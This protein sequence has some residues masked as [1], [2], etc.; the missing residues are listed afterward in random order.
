MLRT[1]QIVGK[2]VNWIYFENFG[3]IKRIV[4]LFEGGK[5][6]QIAM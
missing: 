2:G 3:E 4:Q 5:S 1:M 6:K